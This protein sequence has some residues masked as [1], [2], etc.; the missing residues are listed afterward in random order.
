MI[1]ADLP[2]RVQRA[3]DA[4]RTCRICPRACG[5]DRLASARGAF[6][7]LGQDAFVYKE[8]LSVGEEPAIAPTFLVDLGGCSLRCLF[9]SEWQHVVEPATAGSV[10][11]DGAWLADRVRRRRQEGARTL[12]FVGGEPI[13][14]LLA[15][16]RA[17]SHV[18]AAIALP[19]VWNTN[20]LASAAALDLLAGV[21]ACWIVD[22]KF[23]NPVCA[24][25]LSGETGFDG[26]HEIERTLA[27]ALAPPTH[28][29]SESYGL[30]PL[31]VRHLLMPGHLDCCTVPA[32]TALRDRWPAAAVNVMTGYLPLGPAAR[33][34]PHAPEL[35]A[36]TTLA[37]RERA[38]DFAR[39]TVPRLWIDGR[40][41]V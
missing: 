11:L 3:E 17:L 13:V 18:P 26:A 30:F 23:G 21:V 5:C 38:L 36:R 2:A 40:A 27:V 10:R 24:K 37:E 7:G 14:N 39:R 12:S 8:L 41:S 32:L 9:C 20:G 25:R 35:H 4:Y 34:L 29:I 15:V 28:N 31:I 19:V 33:R 16:L 22:W 6:C 1:A